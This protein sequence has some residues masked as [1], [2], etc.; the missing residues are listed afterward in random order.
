MTSN[1]PHKTK[2]LDVSYSS[3]I[4]SK[5]LIQMKRRHCWQFP[6]SNT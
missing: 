6:I 2:Q 1:L 3:C 4:L 5:S